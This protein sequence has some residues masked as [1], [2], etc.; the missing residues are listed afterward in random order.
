[1]L[2]LEPETQ[3]GPLQGVT[4][5]QATA[6]A[7]DDEN[8]E[9]D[10]VFIPTL[11]SSD[12]SGSATAATGQVH[13]TLAASSNRLVF[14]D[15]LSP[16]LALSSSFNR[17]WAASD[18]PLRERVYW[19]TPEELSNESGCPID[20]REYTDRSLPAPRKNTPYA[21]LY[22]DGE[23]PDIIPSGLRIRLSARRWDLLLHK[24]ESRARFFE[25][26]S[27]AEYHDTPAA[28]IRRDDSPG[29]RKE[30]APG[31]LQYLLDEIDQQTE[32]ESHRFFR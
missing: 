23:E 3:T 22:K 14:K 10:E 27:I 17:I 6:L 19:P 31:I 20:N 26:S 16:V 15:E 11:Y 25:Q 29:I 30:D 7:E 5:P 1:M 21:N 32:E 4:L 13:G 18:L 9:G 28:Q 2:E 24:E 8:E 12:A